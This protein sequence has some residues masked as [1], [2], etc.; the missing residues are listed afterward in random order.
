[1]NRSSSHRKRSTKRKNP[2]RQ[3]Q[4][5]RDVILRA[6]VPDKILVPLIYH[7][8]E[9]FTGN[10]FIDN[11]FNLNSLFD[12]DRT[13]IG[14]QPLGHDQW[15][16]FYGRYRVDKVKVEITAVN[17][18]ND[19]VTITDVLANNDS[20]AIVTGTLFDSA[21]EAPFSNVFMIG[22]NSGMNYHKFSRTYSLNQI[23]GATPVKYQ[24]DDTYAALVTSSPSEIITLHVC[25]AD[26]AFS[27]NI[28]MF[29]DIKLT[30]F[31]TYFDRK[32]LPQS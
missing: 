15:S 27:T 28:D 17:N 19:V 1:M 31:A 29:Y 26:L 11:V 23:A 32:V 4:P 5:T 20:S 30:Y 18:S 14:H 10:I 8:R 6:T 3:S 16:E 21:C 22:G 7:A 9:V 2:F 24:T 25:A 13:G 12:P